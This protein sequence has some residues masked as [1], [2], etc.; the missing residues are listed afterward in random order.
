MLRIFMGAIAGALL[1]A[2]LSG[3]ASSKNASEREWAAAECGRVI[4]A[5]ARKKCLER[6]DDD[7]GRR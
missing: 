5:D 2:A 1:C 6:V 4:D 7:Y 3:C